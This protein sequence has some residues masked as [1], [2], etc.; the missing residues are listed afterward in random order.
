MILEIRK[1]DPCQCN[2]GCMK[3]VC[4]DK[5]EIP[6][7]FRSHFKKTVPDGIIMKSCNRQSVFPVIHKNVFLISISLLCT[8]SARLCTVSPEISLLIE[9]RIGAYFSCRGQGL[10][11][12]QFLRPMPHPEN[13]L[14]P[15][16][17]EMSLFSRRSGLSG[18]K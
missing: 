11:S 9:S 4:E 8:F 16:V 15:S 2:T 14:S 10:F 3:I 5:I 18:S 12:S 6:G 1:S 7:I 17:A 13:D